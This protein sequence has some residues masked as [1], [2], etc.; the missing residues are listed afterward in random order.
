MTSQRD[1]FSAAGVLE[2]AT[3]LKDSYFSHCGTLNV[4]FS[5]FYEKVFQFKL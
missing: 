3:E 5:V 2:Q 4:C 1:D